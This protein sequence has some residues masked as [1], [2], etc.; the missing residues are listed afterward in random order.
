M[1]N[2]IQTQITSEP[3]T[4]PVSLAEAKLYLRVDSSDEDDLITSMIVSARQ[5]IENPLRS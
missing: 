1:Y 3:A 4:E 5:M 2:A